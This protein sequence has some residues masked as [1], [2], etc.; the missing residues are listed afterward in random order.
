MSA[1]VYEPSYI[2]WQ[3]LIIARATATDLTGQILIK[4]GRA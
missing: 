3:V 4:G 2:L 1:R